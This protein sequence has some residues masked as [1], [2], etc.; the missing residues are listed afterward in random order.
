MPDIVPSLEGIDGGLYIVCQ[1]SEGDEVRVERAAALKMCRMLSDLMEESPEEGEVQTSIPVDIETEPLMRLFSY[2]E[3]RV[4]HTD[5]APYLGKG[6]DDP[7]I[8]K[9]VSRKLDYLFENPFDK[10]FMIGPDG[11]IPNADVSNH[12]LMLD[13]LRASNYLHCEWIKDLCVS[14]IASFVMGRNVDKVR[15]DVFKMQPATDAEKKAYQERH[16]WIDKQYNIDTIV[17]RQE[18][19]TRRKTKSKKSH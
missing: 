3:Y 1:S 12:T 2:C 5:E 6:F 19:G 8:Q 14:A 9:P 10:N 11:A 4:H 7:I 17:Q 18:Q 16:S 13:I 15:S